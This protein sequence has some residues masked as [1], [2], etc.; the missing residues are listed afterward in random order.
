MKKTICV[1]LACL[2]AVFAFAGCGEKDKTQEKNAQSYEITLDQTS[3][4]I[5][6][7]EKVVLTATVKDSAG[8]AA[9]QTVIW[10]SA[11]PAVAEV[12]DGTVFA[13]G[14][15]KTTVTAKLEDG[16][17]ATCT[18]E[19]NYTGMV[20]Q[21]VISNA[22]GSLSVAKGE[23]FTL[24]LGVEYNGKDCT[25]P[26]TAYL[27]EVAAPSVA[28]VSADGVITG[29]SEGTTELT[30]IAD[31][32]GLGGKNLDGGE[33]AYGLKQVIQIAVVNP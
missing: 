6:V 11:N 2:M 29:V 16:T 31:W 3:V 12:T 32:R 27:F 13:K 5:G 14:A 22:S 9:Q 17:E 33:D 1:L 26:D 18:V 4:S 21:L 15:G 24:E 19:A 20:P 23:A 25:D 30:V 7:Y 8:Q 28:T 10:T